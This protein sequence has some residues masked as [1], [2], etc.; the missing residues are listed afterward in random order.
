MVASL[1]CQFRIRAKLA[2]ARSVISDPVIMS[3]IV[4]AIWTSN[5]DA[6]I[7]RN[8]SLGDFA[9]R[10]STIVELNLMTMSGAMRGHILDPSSQVEYRRK[11]AADDQFSKGI[12]ELKVTLAEMPSVLHRI[13]EIES[14]DDQFLD[15]AEDHL[16]EMA[17]VDTEAAKRFYEI[18]YLPL[19]ER[20][21]GPILALRREIKQ[22][23]EAVR[24][25]AAATHATQLNRNRL[26]FHPRRVGHPGGN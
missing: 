6:K 8:L 22:V 13:V 21:T 10:Q 14:Y 17:T 7:L 2:L 9:D 12:K 25:K 5:R 16:L 15:K 26:K 24:V 19:R 18:D 4:A 23:K 1:Q 3:A 11:I 20:E